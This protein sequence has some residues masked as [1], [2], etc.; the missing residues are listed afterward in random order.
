[1]KKFNL[2]VFHLIFSDC[3]AKDSFCFA[4][5]VI[6]IKQLR[7]LKKNPKFY[8]RVKRMFLRSSYLRKLVLRLTYNILS[9]SE[10]NNLLYP[11]DF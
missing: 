5:L 1:M 10:S 8:A 11:V 3:C 7:P 4:V 6:F 2:Y 9:V